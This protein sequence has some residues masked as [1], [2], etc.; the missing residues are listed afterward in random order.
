METEYFIDTSSEEKEKYPLQFKITAKTWDCDTAGVAANTG[1]KF[2]DYSTSHFGCVAMDN[3]KDRWYLTLTDDGLKQTFVVGE[4]TS[5]KAKHK[6]VLEGKFFN[7]V[8]QHIIVNKENGELR[9]LSG[10]PTQSQ[11]V[12]QVFKAANVKDLPEL[13]KRANVKYL[14]E[15]F[16]RVFLARRS[17]DDK[18][19]ENKNITNDCKKNT[20]PDK[21]DNTLGNAFCQ[22]IAELIRDKEFVSSLKSEGTKKRFGAPEKPFGLP[23]MFDNKIF[24]NDATVVKEALKLLDNKEIEKKAGA[25]CK[26]AKID[27]EKCAVEWQND[28]DNVDRGVALKQAYF[29]LRVMATYILMRDIDKHNDLAK[30]LCKTFSMFLSSENEDSELK[31]TMLALLQRYLQIP[32]NKRI[33]TLLESVT[34]N[35]HAFFLLKKKKET[36]LSK[37]LEHVEKCLTTLV[38]K[39]RREFVI[40]KT[41]ERYDR[42][43]ELVPSVLRSMVN[44]MSQIKRGEF[45]KRTSL[46]KEEYRQWF[47]AVSPI[48]SDTAMFCYEFER[49]LYYDMYKIISNAF[50]ESGKLIDGYDLPKKLNEC[51]EAYGLTSSFKYEGEYD[52]CSKMGRLAAKFRNL[53]LPVEVK[54]IKGDYNKLLKKTRNT[55]FKFIE[56][57]GDS[58]FKKC[59]ISVSQ[60]VKNQL[61]DVI[62]KNS[63]EGLFS[64]TMLK[65]TTNQIDPTKGEINKDNVKPLVEPQVKPPKQPPVKPSSSSENPLAGQQTFGGVGNKIAQVGDKDIVKPVKNPQPVPVKNLQPVEE[66]KD[67]NLP[68]GQQTFGGEGNKFVQVGGKD[69]NIFRL[70]DTN[71]DFFDFDSIKSLNDDECILIAGNPSRN[72]D[73]G[74]MMG[75]AGRLVARTINGIGK[76]MKFKESFEQGLQDSFKEENKQFLFPAKVGAVNYTN[77][78]DPSKT[79]Q[80]VYCVGVGNA[81]DALRR[82]KDDN[83][84]K[85]VL[86]EFIKKQTLLADMLVDMLI[87]HNNAITVGGKIQKLCI[88]GIGNGEWAPEGEASDSTN[89]IKN[90]HIA[91]DILGHVLRV[92]AK[93]LK[94]AG[95]SLFVAGPLAKVM[96]NGPSKTISGELLKKYHADQGNEAKNLYSEVINKKTLEGIKMFLTKYSL[97]SEKL[98]VEWRDVDFNPNL[99]SGG[100]FNLPPSGIKKTQ[101]DINGDGKGLSNGDKKQK[102][103]YEFL[104]E[105]KKVNINDIDFGDGGKENIEDIDNSSEDNSDESNKN[106]EDKSGKISSQLIDQPKNNGKDSNVPENTNE[107]DNTN[108]TTGN[109]VEG[110]GNRN[111]G[112]GK[113]SSNRS[114]EPLNKNRN[115][116][117]P[118]KNKNINTFNGDFILK[119]K[120]PNRS[121]KKG[122]VNSNTSNNRGNLTNDQSNSNNSF[123]SRQRRYSYAG[124][125]L[126]QGNSLKNNTSGGF[127]TSVNIA[128]SKPLVT[129]PSSGLTSISLKSGISTQTGKQGVNGI[130]LNTKSVNGPQ[131]SQSAPVSNSKQDS[132]NIGDV[133]NEDSNNKKTTSKENNNTA[134]AAGA[135]LLGASGA[136]VAVLTLTDV[137]SGVPVVAKV[138][139]GIGSAGL[140][141]LSIYFGTSSPDKT[142]NGEPENNLNTGQPQAQK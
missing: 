141:G 106:K 63:E 136:V 102:S 67:V 105:V 61:K 77:N 15:L 39:C 50:D 121:S 64:F 48:S 135:G 139:I 75:A 128:Q 34:T 119:G 52:I 82:A 14:P 100:R 66:K 72:L 69:S 125:S 80:A 42:I 129:A 31:N 95:I 108:N 81:T 23:S 78:N 20:I 7:D 41:K 140:I 120:M 117:P 131:T 10:E 104:K 17:N 33:K 68:V 43:A 30:N 118:L 22:Q 91:D 93:E 58:I 54:Y 32:D 45:D 11:V 74:G 85:A 98:Q 24:V 142:N 115:V 40:G 56:L 116:Q 92:R 110:N 57:V 112:D 25:L 122:G 55:P 47:D 133:N 13:F 134:I 36:D 138:I 5:K 51:F 79:M 6:F 99:S 65:N 90:S 29:N 84:K 87:E 111:V 19:F 130:S 8:R 127:T 60:K 28:K 44:R 1:L 70:A 123:P 35:L 2:E 4:A 107:E 21:K 73:G 9:D 137:I 97:K 96:E 38:A 113:T 37:W 59:F 86:L 71:K 124:N 103:I 12:Q 46:G 83:E 132:S 76:P 16:K 18:S 126:S 101:E 3:K 26:Q 27:F 88:N 109:G 89:R 62:D 114:L 53:I 49:K 94:D